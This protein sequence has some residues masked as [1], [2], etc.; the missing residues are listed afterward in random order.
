M[1]TSPIYTTIV[2]FVL[3]KIAKC[4]YETRRLHSTAINLVAQKLAERVA[5]RPMMTTANKRHAIID[6]VYCEWNHGNLVSLD[7]KL[8]TKDAL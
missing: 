6:I 7:N 4:Q 8:Y 1:K 5:K 3:G 2:E